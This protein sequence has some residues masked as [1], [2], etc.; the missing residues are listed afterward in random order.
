MGRESS[1]LIIAGEWERKIE[2]WWKM[3]E[4][5]SNLR[6]HVVTAGMQEK[7]SETVTHNFH[8]PHHLKIYDRK[9]HQLLLSRW[10]TCWAKSPLADSVPRWWSDPT[11]R[12]VCAPMSIAPCRNLHRSDLSWSLWAAVHSGWRNMRHSCHLAG[13]TSRRRADSLRFLRLRKAAILESCSPMTHKS[14]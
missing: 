4:I 7:T 6:E 11:C 10:S 12:T 5:L 1:H 13:P 14:I 2:R 9:S 3:K 8:P